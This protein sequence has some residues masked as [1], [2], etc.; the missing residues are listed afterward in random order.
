ML[1]TNFKERHD[2][3]GNTANVGVKRQSI[4]QSINQSTLVYRRLVN[5]WAF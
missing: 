3:S 5:A 2:I 4:N 1:Y